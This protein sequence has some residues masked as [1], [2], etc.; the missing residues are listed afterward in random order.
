MRIYL[1]MC[2][3]NRQFDEKISEED[4]IE[5]RSVIQIQKEI[6][7]DNL[8][9]VTSFMLHYENYRKKISEQRDK[10]DL[11]IKTYRKIYVGVDSIEILK[12]I[13]QKI[14]SHGIQVFC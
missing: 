8:D 11:F 12:D 10:I 5:A 13:S 9:L 3:Y 2:C 4:F 1:D 14:I 6:L 7:L